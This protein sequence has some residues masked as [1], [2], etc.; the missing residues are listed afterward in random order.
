MN[1]LFT[2]IATAFVGMA[3]AIGVGVAVDYRT[4]EAAR[5][6]TGSLTITRSCFP[7]GS[8]A[9]NAT[10][11]WSATAS[12][13][14]TVSGQGDLYSTANQTTMQTKN[15][16][17]STHYHNTSA[18]PGAIT[19]IALSVASGTDRTYT[20]YATTGSAITSTSGLTSVGTV[21]GASALDLNSSSGYKYFWLNCGGGASFLNSITITYEVSSGQENPDPEQLTAPTIS[22]SGTAV[23]WGSVSNASGYAYSIKHRKS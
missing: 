18:M 6:E 2:K 4:A 13:G 20:V 23:S 9:Y 1:K 10:D 14:E 3:M 19:N 16:G 15:S 11:E 22:I 5:A 21:T 8:L 12:T 17:V 7:S